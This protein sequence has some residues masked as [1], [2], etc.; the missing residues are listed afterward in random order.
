MPTSSLLLGAGG[1]AGG[2]TTYANTTS[3]LTNDLTG[4]LAA[5][6]IAPGVIVDADV[7]PT[8]GVARS[9]L[10]AVEAVRLFGAAGNPAYGT[11]W[12]QLTTFAAGFWKDDASG[13]V[14]LQGVIQK[15][16][17]TG[18]DIFA[19]LPAG[20]RPPNNKAIGIMVNANAVN[21]SSFLNITTAG[22][23]YLS[24]DPVG[25]TYIYLDNISFRL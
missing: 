21:Y 8:A 25:A 1:L 5:P 24:E 14:Y 9:K 20:Y 4:T 18:A 6:E 3:P 16:N 22:A 11:G 17:P 10:A 2:S 15:N 13:I 23:M 12:S 7:S 19:T